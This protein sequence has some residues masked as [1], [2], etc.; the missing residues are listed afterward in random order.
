M[1]KLLKDIL[2]SEGI[3]HLFK[4]RA[5]GMISA[6][7]GHHTEKQN[8]DLTSQLGKALKNRGHTVIPAKGGY[9]ENFGTDVAKHSHEDS[10]VVAHKTQGDDHGALLKD[11]T[12]LGAR[13]G[14]DSIL[15]KPHNSDVASFHGTTDGVWPGKGK[16]E[17]VGRLNTKSKN[18]QYYTELPNG[19]RFSFE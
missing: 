19:K 8:A 6:V 7:K 5:V 9:V 1:A 18:P 2:I 12:E 16:V 4:N 13:Y 11:L 17:P 3:E 10:F 15:H 14:Q